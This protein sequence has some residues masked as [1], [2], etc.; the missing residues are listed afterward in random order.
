MKSMT[1]FSSVLAVAA[2]AL[3]TLATTGCASTREAYKAADTLDERAFVAEEHFAAVVKQAADMKDRGVLTGSALANVRA[4]E[5]KAKPAVL[6]LGD[7]ARK[8]QAAQT[9]E[10][11]VALQ[12]ALDSVVLAIADLVR[13]LKTATGGAT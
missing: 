4:L 7:L 6:S 3:C 8:W 2:I 5:A 11:E 12:R 10:S 9:A 1:R 13:A